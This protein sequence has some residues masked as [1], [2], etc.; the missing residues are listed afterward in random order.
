MYTSPSQIITHTQLNP[1]TY[2]IFI[3]SSLISDFTSQFF[4]PS[5]YSYIRSLFS[6]NSVIIQNSS[7][8]A[9]SSSFFTLHLSPFSLLHSPSSST[10]VQFSLGIAQ[11]EYNYIPNKSEVNDNLM[12][13][14]NSF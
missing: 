1:I 12:L 4:M 3:P 14:K 9:H 6:H 10:L 8:T 2:L 7:V 11:F 13:N 5:S